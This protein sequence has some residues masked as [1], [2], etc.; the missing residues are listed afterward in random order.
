M[1]YHW[2]YCC[3][4]TRALTFPQ[5]APQPLQEYA[6]DNLSFFAL[7]AWNGDFYVKV[8]FGLRSFLGFFFP[9]C[10]FFLHPPPFLTSSH[11]SVQFNIMCDSRLR[12]GQVNNSS[13]LRAAVC[14][15]SLH[16]L[17]SEALQQWSALFLPLT[18]SG[19]AHAACSPAEGRGHRTHTVLNRLCYKGDK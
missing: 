4:C 2:V 9:P 5:L 12:Q 15:A 13:A 8:P 3:I 1:N 17:P 18:T 10:C 14:R 7:M 6:L 11:S 19:P 16:T